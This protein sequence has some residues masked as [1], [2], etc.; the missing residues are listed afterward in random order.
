MPLRWVQWSPLTS[1]VITSEG[2]QWKWMRQA[3]RNK[4]MV[5]EMAKWWGKWRRSKV[6]NSAVNYVHHAFGNLSSH[7]A[8]QVNQTTEIW[9]SRPSFTLYKILKMINKKKIIQEIELI[10][11][12]QELLRNCV[13]S[14]TFHYEILDRA[15]ERSNIANHQKR[16]RFNGTELFIL[17]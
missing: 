5:W 8:I 4:H 12:H 14:A 15:R 11:K 9:F 13:K 17:I 6:L 1:C 7:K 10:W 16:M 2:T 3:G